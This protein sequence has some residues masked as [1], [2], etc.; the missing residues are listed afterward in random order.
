LRVCGRK[1]LFLACNVYRIYNLNGSF[2]VII[3]DGRCIAKVAESR[4]D[5]KEFPQQKIVYCKI[6]IEC[7]RL[8][9]RAYLSYLN[10]QV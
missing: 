4:L 7:K 2:V 6:G 9:T 3:H 8:Q 5:A 1:Y 10:T